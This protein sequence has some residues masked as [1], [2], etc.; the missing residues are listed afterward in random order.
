MSFEYF[1]RLCSYE[2]ETPETYSPQL[3]GEVDM[4]EH[5]NHMLLSNPT[6]MGEFNEGTDLTCVRANGYAASSWGDDDY[7]EM[8]S[9]PCPLEIPQGKQRATRMSLTV[10]EPVPQDNDKE[11]EIPPDPTHTRVQITLYESGKYVKGSAKNIEIPQP[12][13]EVYRNIEF[14]KTLF[15]KSNTHTRVRVQLQNKVNGKMMG[16]ANL[17]LPSATVESV[18]N[19]IM[20]MADLKGWLAP[21]PKDVLPPHR[22]VCEEKPCIS[23]ELQEQNEDGSGFSGTQARTDV[24]PTPHGYHTSLSE[25]DRANL[26]EQ[27]RLLR[28]Q[29]DLLRARNSRKKARV[30]VQA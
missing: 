23:K 27:I 7:A 4:Q 1:K 22:G 25:S 28:E 26:L 14:L 24:P 9:Q 20:D 16:G 11:L 15:P 12:Y 18:Y 2:R 5:H 6:Y 3:S 19:N 29:N 21:R 10:P 13:T 8:C 30:S 17:S